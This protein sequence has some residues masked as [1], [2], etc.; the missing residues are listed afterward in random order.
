VAVTPS[1]TVDFAEGVCRALYIGT[2]GAVVAVVNGTAVTFANTQSG[3]VVP[4][5]ASR[6]NST[7]TTASDIV[8]L[9]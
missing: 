5:Q 2:G 7:S 4:I 8:A 6:V 1:D 9:Y 3:S